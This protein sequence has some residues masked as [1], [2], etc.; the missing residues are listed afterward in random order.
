MKIGVDKNAFG[1]VMLVADL[2]GFHPTRDE[3][4]RWC[5]TAIEYEGVD[6]DGVG[7]WVGLRTIGEINAEE[8]QML[9]ESSFARRSE[10]STLSRL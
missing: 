5:K 2:Y 1:A 7:W 3:W 4:F 8:A 9:R 10:C 6:P